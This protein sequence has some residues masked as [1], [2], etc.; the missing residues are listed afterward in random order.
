[1]MNS[2]S[3]LGDTTSNSYSTPFLV[4]ILRVDSVRVDTLTASNFILFYSS[5]MKIDSAKQLTISNFSL[6]QIT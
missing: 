2:D 1:M 4:D 5:L 6:N 3:Q